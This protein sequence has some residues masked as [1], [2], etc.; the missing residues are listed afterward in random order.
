[1]AHAPHDSPQHDPR[2]DER[3]SDVS[4]QAP[5]V[6][7]IGEDPLAW[8]VPLLS[9]RTF[10][11]RVHV[12][13]ILWMGAE[14]VAWV[15]RGAVG[16]VHVFAAVV[17][18]FGVL[19]VRECARE[20]I[21]RFTGGESQ[22][23]VLWPLGGLGATPAGPVPRPFLAETGGLLAGALLVPVLG[24]AVIASGAG[25]QALMLDLLSPGVTAGGLRSYW[26]IW[27]WWAYYAN[28]VVLVANGLLPMLPMDAGR[29]VRTLAAQRGESA[30]RKAVRVAMFASLAVFVFGACMGELRILAMGVLGAFTSYMD[31]RRSE[32]L[33]A[34][35]AQADVEAD[36][37]TETIPEGDVEERPMEDASPVDL[38]AVLRQ[39]S[40]RGLESLSPEQREVLRRETDRRRRR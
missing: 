38:D 24:Y 37:E 25:W 20:L 3:P 17:S 28:A 30:T 11:L 10:R 22:P 31:L 21:R 2:G 23:V 33:A 29:L 35:S 27:A 14:M 5:R 39:I 40:A 13:L 26:Q 9:I 34:S 36:G 12:L 4:W 15:P 1:M 19:V 18:I 16:L 7:G 8:T 32:F 6:W